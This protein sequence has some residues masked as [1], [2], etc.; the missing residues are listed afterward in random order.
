MYEDPKS[1]ISELERVLDAREDLVTKKIKRH[2]LHDRDSSV[3]QDWDDNEFKVGSEISS[4]GSEEEPVNISPEGKKGLSFST[5]ILIGSIFFFLL[6][7]LIVAYNFLMGGNLVSG[8]NIDVTVKAPV[9]V[10]GGEVVSFEIEISNNNSTT[11]VGADLGMTFPL[12]TRDGVD[13]TKEVKRVQAFLGDILPGQSIKK[14]MSVILFGVE[15]EKKQ[16][17]I[18]LEYKVVGSNSLFNKTKTVTILIGSAPVSLVV[19]GPNEVNTNQSVDYSV[20]ITSNSPTVIR[21]LLLKAD[22]P[23]GFTFS[24]S[25]PKTFT[26]NNLWLVGD[27]EP[28]AKRVIKFSGILSGQEG[29]ER[30]FNFSLGSQSKSN[31]QIIDTLFSSSFSSV[32]IRRPFVSAD[33]FLNGVNSSEVV[34]RAG[35]KIEAVIKWQNNLPYEVS[36]VSL[37]V[38]INGNSVNKSS[39]QVNGGFYRSADNMI[40]FNKN[41]NPALALLEPAITGESSFS[42]NSFS[43]SS[44]TGGGLINPTISLEILVNG[45]RVDYQGGQDQVLFSDSRKI[46][47]TSDPQLS[48]KALYYIGPFKNSGSLPPRAE[49]ETT[50]TITWTVVNPLNNLSNTQVSATLPPYMKW[51]GAISP[52]Q[53]KIDYDNGTGQVTWSLGNISAGAGSVSQ[54][55]EVSFQVSLLPSVSQIGSAPELISSA[56]LNAKDSFTLTPVSDSSNALNTRLSSDPYFQGVDDLVVQ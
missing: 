12:G 8:N 54:A 17:D 15:N 3:K 19:T 40:I 56:I 24:S 7:V 23:F 18:N 52:S 49:K 9:S 50:Y 31:N 1:K 21:G 39:I 35:E 20:E 5:K 51:L 43:A 38:K 41:T 32:T 26:K 44:V 6:A 42:F 46:K 10:A 33:I 34:S 28:G 53:E 25:N 14:N 48:A 37:A 4:P 45:S 29:E 16:I 13:A 36:N 47:I 22:Y 55:K 30:G 2:E 11:L 27:L